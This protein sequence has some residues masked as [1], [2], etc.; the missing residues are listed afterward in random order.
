MPH[1]AS[2]KLMVPTMSK[3]MWAGSIFFFHWKASV[4]LLRLEFV[5]LDWKQGAVAEWLM[6]GT[7]NPVFVGSNPARASTS[8]Y[9]ILPTR[10][11]GDKD[12]CTSR[13]TIQ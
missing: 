2:V 11:L 7:A 3:A 10:T 9:N 12:E 6:R 1:T 8:E 5:V 13:L 4:F